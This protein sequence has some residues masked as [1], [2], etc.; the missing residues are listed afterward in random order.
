MVKNIFED[1]EMGKDNS[2]GI[3]LILRNPKMDT[4]QINPNTQEATMQNVG[5]YARENG[6]NVHSQL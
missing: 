2:Q 3:E 4:F 6:A 1:E 5:S